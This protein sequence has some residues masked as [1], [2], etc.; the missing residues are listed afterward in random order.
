MQ[1]HAYTSA[2]KPTYIAICMGK[3]TTHR[4]LQK[5]REVES[6]NTIYQ[7]AEWVQGVI[8]YDHGY[9]AWE[10]SCK[11]SILLATL[12]HTPLWWVLP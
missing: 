5:S 2:A 4:V 11:R 9:N 6:G 10:H 7:H 3:Q 8:H 12:S 1:N